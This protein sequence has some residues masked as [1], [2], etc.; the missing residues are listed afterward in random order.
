[1]AAG[2]EVPAFGLKER[3]RPFRP[4]P[5]RVTAPSMQLAFCSERAV[6]ISVLPFRRGT[7][8]RAVACGGL[9]LGGSTTGAVT[10]VPLSAR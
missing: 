1:M 5:R 4:R 8:Q 10:P 6:A 2:S 7:T 3:T 9:L